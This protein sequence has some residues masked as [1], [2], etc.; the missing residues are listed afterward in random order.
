MTGTVL[1]LTMAYVAVAALLLN[2][3][4]ATRYS[5]RLKV[6]VI[7]LV[8]M[9][10]VVTWQGNWSLLGW[11]SREIMPDLFR[12]LWITIEDPDKETSLPGSIYYWVRE[13]D[14]ASGPYG[15]PRAYALIWSESEAEEAQ[16]ALDLMDEGEIMNG[17]RTRALMAPLGDTPLMEDEGAL[18]QRKAGDAQ[19]LPSFE[20]RQA[21]RP[22]LPAK[23]APR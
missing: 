8:S 6:A 16:R 20:F 1:L 12:V 21:K 13:L 11:P 19:G 23:E 15:P 7:F 5:V 9:F 17:H 3:T 22:S 14:L 2:L 4:L 10:Y 18:A